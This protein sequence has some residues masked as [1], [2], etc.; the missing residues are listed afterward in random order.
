MQ[1]ALKL[2]L[3]LNISNDIFKIFLSL[4]PPFYFFFE[5]SDSE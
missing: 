5:G 3:R 1:L 4:F 2:I